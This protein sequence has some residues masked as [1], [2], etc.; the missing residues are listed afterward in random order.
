MSAEE[1]VRSYQQFIDAKKRGWT[2]AQL[3][4]AAK[5]LHEAR[6]DHDCMD[7]FRLAREGNSEEGM[8]Y[9]DT[10]RNGCCGSRDVIL[11][12]PDGRIEVG[13]NYGH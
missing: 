7:N 4:I 9:D 6:E 1:Y 5:H 11:D 3:E 13:F 10:A 2:D 12:T 8:A